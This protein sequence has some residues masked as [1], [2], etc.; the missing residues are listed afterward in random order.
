MGAEEFSWEDAPARHSRM[1]MN[2][3]EHELTRS[4]RAT[5]DKAADA[6]LTLALD[7]RCKKLSL[8][9]QT[10]LDLRIFD[11]KNWSFNGGHYGD[12]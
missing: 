2:A 1:T 4:R 3:P 9:S 8:G 12:D 7:I 11:F 6:I 10:Q 5:I